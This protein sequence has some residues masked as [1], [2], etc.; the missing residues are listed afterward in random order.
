FQLTDGVVLGGGIDGGWAL[1]PRTRAT[2][3]LVA[4]RHLVD[5]TG[6]GVDWT[7]VRGQVRLEWT[8]GPEPGMSG[9]T[10]RR[11]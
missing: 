11:P 9:S 2:A 8:L 6:T 7:Q 1:N 3:H 4:Y 10:G 5:R